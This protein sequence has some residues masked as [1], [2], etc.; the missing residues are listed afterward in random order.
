[1]R[2]LVTGSGGML[3]QD[4]IPRLRE[5]G[6]EVVSPPES[7][8]DITDGGAIAGQVSSAAPDL[9]VNCAAYNYVD[10]AETRAAQANLINGHAVRELCLACRERDIP[11]VHFSTDYVFDG[12]KGRPYAVHDAANP[13]NAY[14]RSKALGE[15]FVVDLMSDYYLIRTS[16]LFGLHGKNFV[17]TMLAKA[18]SEGGLAVVDS[19]VGC[20]TWT[21]H[22]ADA[23]VDLI[24][25]GRGGVYHAVNSGSTTWHGFA[26]E[27]L[28]LSGIEVPL[29]RTSAEAL[30][31]AARRPSYSVLDPAPL[32]DVLGRCMPSWQEALREYLELR[33][34]R[35][36]G[37]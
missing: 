29:R 15:R 32:P 18:R 3:A 36:P 37:S 8:L 25:T 33:G 6:H 16:W 1:M 11:I 27:I 2:V 26:A 17:E 7:E 22:L 20:P 4:L 34:S 31:R 28:R 9:L 12:T 10:L 21:A 13:I 14:G 23:V 30:G 5:R 35:R 19:E 24:E